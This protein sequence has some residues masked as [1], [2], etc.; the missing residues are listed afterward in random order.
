MSTPS[1]AYVAFV[2]RYIDQDY[3]PEPR[4][5][6][7]CQAW[8]AKQVNELLHAGKYYCWFATSLNSF[9]NG[10]DSNPIMIYMTVDRAIKQGG[11]NNA[12]IKDIRLNLMRAVNKELAR[13]QR[14]TEIASTQS[15]IAKAPLTW[16]RPEIWRLDLNAIKG[17]Y[18][19]GHQYSDEFL[20]QDLA[21]AEFEII[22][23]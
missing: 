2:E 13:Q 9:A 16:L 1:K 6:Y 21:K 15:L 8:L 14:S 12:K 17:R 18:T 7:S 5:G 19:G 23:E 22:V 20:L 3:A 11:F 10:D 4:Y